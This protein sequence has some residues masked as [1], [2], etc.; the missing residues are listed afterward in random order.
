MAFTPDDELPRPSTETYGG[1]KPFGEEEKD[2]IRNLTLDES[3][4]DSDEY[5]ADD[6]CEGT[7]QQSQEN[8]REESERANEAEGSSSYVDM[9]ENTWK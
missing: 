7:S 6:P 4:K 8:E 3:D 9:W 5:I 1:D 2:R